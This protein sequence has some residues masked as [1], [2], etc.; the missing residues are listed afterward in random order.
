MYRDQDAV[1]AH[2][3][4][5]QLKE[6]QV[7]SFAESLCGFPFEFWSGRRVSNSRPQPW[8]GCALPTELLP[9]WS[10]LLS[11]KCYFISSAF[12]ISMT[13]CCSTSFHWSGRRVSNSRP[14]PWQGCALPTELLPHLEQ[15]Y[16]RNF[17][18]IPAILFLTYS[19]NTG[20]GEEARTL[21]LNLGK[22]ALYQLSY[23]RVIK[24]SIIEDTG[25]LSR[26]AK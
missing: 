12:Y 6:R 18:T 20:A 19:K 25:R 4:V 10:F 24:P 9:H 26:A 7:R 13:I 21:D 5:L 8:Q 2:R 17:T 11:Q 1:A 23:S 15:H 16:R 14:Q 3:V 22:V